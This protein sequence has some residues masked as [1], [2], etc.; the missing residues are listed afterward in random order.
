M[1]DE[2]L[3]EFVSQFLAGLD[4]EAFERMKPGPVVNIQLNSYFALH[5]GS[6]LQSLLV[7]SSH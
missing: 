5:F 4:L 2:P 6:Q 1:S 7:V 3:R